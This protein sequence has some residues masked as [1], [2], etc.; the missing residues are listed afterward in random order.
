MTTREEIWER[1]GK[2]FAP[3]ETIF[4]EGEMGHPM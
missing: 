2:V 4:S 1:Y 3:E